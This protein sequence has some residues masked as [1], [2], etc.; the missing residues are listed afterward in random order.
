[1]IGRKKI[2]QGAEK[3]SLSKGK[4]IRGRRERATYARRGNR[5]QR[6]EEHFA[7]SSTTP[8][9][10]PMMI[11]NKSLIPSLFGQISSRSAQVSG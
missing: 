5:R 1:M 2:V 10:V 11:S 9:T 7:N 8:V 4:T 3:E 6:S